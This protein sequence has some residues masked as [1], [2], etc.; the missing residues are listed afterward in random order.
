MA[1]RQ[2]VPDNSRSSKLT[3]CGHVLWPTN[4]KADIGTAAAKA[5]YVRRTVIQK[6]KFLQDVRMAAFEK[7]HH[8]MLM[9]STD[10]NCPWNWR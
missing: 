2:T 8:S 4:P 7:L 10:R 6:L 3:I 5:R 1:S 9:Y